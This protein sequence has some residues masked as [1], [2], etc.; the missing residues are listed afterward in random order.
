MEPVGL[1]AVKVVSQVQSQTK[2]SQPPSEQAIEQ[3]SYS[4]Q[5][6]RSTKGPKSTAQKVARVVS[7][8]QIQTTVSRV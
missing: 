2:V 6:P 4:A 3:V 5:K 7:Q 8:V 1:E